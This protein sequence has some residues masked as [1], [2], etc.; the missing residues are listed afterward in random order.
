VE[1]ALHRD[2]VLFARNTAHH[3]ERSLYGLRARIDEKE[4]V[5]RRVRH[6]G[7]QT[8]YET[9]IGLVVCDGTLIIVQKKRGVSVEGWELPVRV[10]D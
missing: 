2:D 3:L 9:Q 10:Q 7:E 6:E 1:R 5:E 4:R 8:F